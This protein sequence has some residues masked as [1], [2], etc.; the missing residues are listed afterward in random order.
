MGP[1]LNSLISKEADPAEL[2]RAMG[3]S[4]GIAALGRVVGPTW[5]GWLYGF[6]PA[7]PF[8]ATAAGLL[9]TVKISRALVSAQPK[10][11][12]RR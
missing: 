2:G 10:S 9:Y 3:M 6:G 4:Q 7:L 1:T 8:L 5:G 12:Q 11:R